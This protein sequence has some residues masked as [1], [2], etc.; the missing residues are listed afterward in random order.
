[1]ANFFT[2]NKDIVF[3][4]ERLP[5]EE[6]TQILENN[7]K[8]AEEFNY[9]PHDYADALDNYRRVLELIGDITA[10]VIA[11]N[12]AGV[13]EEGAHF[14]NGKVTYAKGTQEN[15]DQLIQAELMGF[16]LPRKYGGLNMPMAIYTMAIEMVAHGDASL[17]NI[18]G[19]QDIAETVQR[20]GSEEQKQEFLPQ[21]SSGEATGAMALTEPDAG[22]DLQAVKMHA[23][24]DDNDSGVC[25]A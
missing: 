2:D 13:D 25:G 14:E 21:F 9:A 1:M 7:Y 10:N 3:Q 19:L 5:L 12:A 4:F 24:Q 8:E 15:M 16:T 11:P 6:V 20:F 23:Y 18:F 17:M 22:S